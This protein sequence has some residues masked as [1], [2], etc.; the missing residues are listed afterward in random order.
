MILFMIVLMICLGENINVYVFYVIFMFLK[1]C[2]M[3]F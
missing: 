1:W 2:F 3:I